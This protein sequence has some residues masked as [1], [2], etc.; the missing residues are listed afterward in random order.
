MIAEF[1]VGRGLWEA[2][3]PIMAAYNLGSHDAIHVATA[4][5][6]DVP[7]I[8]TCDDDLKRVGQPRVQI[9]S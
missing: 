1:L 4:Q 7:L 5:R 9:T 8:V 2:S 3:I 6:H